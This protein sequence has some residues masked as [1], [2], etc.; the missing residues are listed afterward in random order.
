MTCNRS[1]SLAPLSQ[2]VSVLRKWNHLHVTARNMNSRPEVRAGLFPE[3][4]FAHR[5]LHLTVNV[6]CW[7]IHKAVEAGD[8]AK[9]KHLLDQGAAVESK[10]GIVGHPFALTDADMV[11]HVPGR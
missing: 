7:Q 4:L 1:G 2:R 11:L 6:L 10:V 9:V 5:R 8:V 3:Q